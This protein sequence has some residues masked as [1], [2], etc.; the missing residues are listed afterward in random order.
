MSQ[1]C[2]YHCIILRYICSIFFSVGLLFWEYAL[3]ITSTQTCSAQTENST[4][5]KFRTYVYSEHI[6]LLIDF[7]YYFFHSAYYIRC[8]NFLPLSA[9]NTLMNANYHWAFICYPKNV[10]SAHINRETNLKRNPFS[11]QA[12]VPRVFSG[13]NFR[14]VFNKEI[15]CGPY[16]VFVLIYDL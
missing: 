8:L 10:P 13:F 3:S 12:N 1:C 4:T 16:N 7:T 15:V 11:Q 5:T 2:V 9:S 14:S 6:K